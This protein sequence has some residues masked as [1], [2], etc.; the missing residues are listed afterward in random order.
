MQGSTLNGEA[1]AF[2][3]TGGDEGL[4]EEKDGEVQ[5]RIVRGEDGSVMEEKMEPVYDELPPGAGASFWF[6]LQIISARLPP[7]V[8]PKK[9]KPG[10]RNPMVRVS[11]NNELQTFLGSK[12]KKTKEMQKTLAPRWEDDALVAR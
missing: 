9:K 4:T 3:Y 6:E 1:G 11:L 7:L 12:K 10:K 5:S 8:D 2:T